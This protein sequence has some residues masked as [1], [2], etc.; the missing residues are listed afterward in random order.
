MNA[1]SSLPTRE[2]IREVLI[3]LGVKGKH[4]DP[5]L[6]EAEAAL[7][8]IFAGHEHGW[9]SRNSA[10]TDDPDLLRRRAAERA[11]NVI[12]RVDPYVRPFI[13][14]RG[15]GRLELNIPGGPDL[16]GLNLA[17]AV[18]VRL[19]IEQANSLLAQ[20]V[21][22]LDTIGSLRTGKDW[23]VRLPRWHAAYPLAALMQAQIIA[24]TTTVSWWGTCTCFTYEEMIA[25]QIVLTLVAAGLIPTGVPAIAVGLT[26]LFLAGL[27]EISA[28]LG[29]GGGACCYT[30]PLGTYWLPQ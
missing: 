23:L 1:D 7:R 10:A 24:T 28:L 8:R 26:D 5:I 22:V 6:S 14:E 12:A 27:S 20:G 16:L 2:Q 9:P 15:N 11:M 17:E 13:G 30:T 21:L 19:G 25:V 29:R 3:R 4:A 18:G